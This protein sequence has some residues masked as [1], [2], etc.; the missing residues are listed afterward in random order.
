MADKQEQA[1]IWQQRTNQQL[2]AELCN[3][4]Y[5]RELARL[6]SDQQVELVQLQKRLSSLPYYI[7]RAAEHICDLYTPLDLD[8]Q[9]GSWI[10]SQATKPFSVKCDQTKTYEFFQRH[11]K[12]ALVVPIAV[13]H[14]GIEQVVLDSIDEID[15][16]GNRLHCNEHGWFQF[17]GVGSDSVNLISKTLLKPSKAVMS[18]ACCGHQWLNL[19]RSS[20]RL[21]SLR[22][23]LLATRINWHQFSKLVA[24]KK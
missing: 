16:E 10:S 5:E 24:P 8:S 9:N 7:K 15:L 6:S 22:E 19:R 23:M 2:F 4:L 14:S 20:P 12:M 18:A 17:D 1:F 13:S 21:L 11:A 3:A